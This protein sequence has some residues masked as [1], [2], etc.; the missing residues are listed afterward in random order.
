MGI[1]LPSISARRHPDRE[2]E[3]VE[4]FFVG[5]DRLGLCLV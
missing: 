1:I 2:P 3:K 4:L 5:I